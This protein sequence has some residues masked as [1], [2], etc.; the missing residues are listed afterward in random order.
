[1]TESERIGLLLADPTKKTLSDG[2]IIAAEIRDFKGSE[3]YKL[4]VEGA[5]YYRNRSTVQQKENPVEN[6]SNTKIEHP[7]LRKL[8]D[9]KA[10]YVL[11]KPFTFKVGN[12]KY[13]EALNAIFDMEARRKLKSLGKG[14]VKQGIAWLQPYI[15][16]AARPGEKAKLRFMRPESTE[17]VPIWADAEK[18]QL[19]GYIHFWE[20][21]IYTGNTKGTMQ[22]AEVCTKRGVQ[23]WTGATVGAGGQAAAGYTIDKR[24]GTEQNGYTAPWLE[25]NG[26]AYELEEV[27]IAWLRYNDE[28]LPL[29][30]FMKDFV[31]DINWQTSVTA[32]VLRDIANFIYVLKNYGGTDLAEFLRD[33]QNNRAVKVAADGGVDKLQADLNIDAVLAFLKKNRD[34]AIY[35]ANGVDTQDADLGNASGD[36]IKFRYMDLDNDCQDLA[37]ALQETFQRLKIFIDVFLQATGQGDFTAE[38]FEVLFNMDMP[39]IEKDVIENAVSSK[40]ILSTKTIL[41]NHPWVTDATAEEEQIMAEKEENMRRFG[42]GLFEDDFATEKP[43]GQQS[44]KAAGA[45]AKAGGEK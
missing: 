3:Q 17:I 25:I 21:I 28:E 15:A 10:N 36:A 30:Y 14:A 16:T 26:T 6:R 1:M 19:E 34:D 37:N 9:Q 38:T 7:L 12:K 5:Q 27:P 32:D 23:H 33:L 39:V 40:G 8:V 41:E 11:A 2:Q 45:T 35:F 44:G 22:H 20:Q 13:G 29:S 4:M 43:A 31:D 18:T 42:E 24:A